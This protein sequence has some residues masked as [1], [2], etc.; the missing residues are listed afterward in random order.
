MRETYP[1]RQMM[2]VLLVFAIIILLIILPGFFK[3]KPNWI[4]FLFAMLLIVIPTLALKSELGRASTFR[5]IAKEKGFS[6]VAKA[7]RNFFNSLPAFQLFQR[8]YAR[9]AYNI[10]KGEIKGKSFILFDF[11]YSVRAPAPVPPYATGGESVKTAIIFNNIDE[12][13]IHN[14]M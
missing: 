14:F 11:Q 8:G 5:K 12:A 13:T 1:M 7:G 4:V 3:E 10:V 2:I 6:F 9:T